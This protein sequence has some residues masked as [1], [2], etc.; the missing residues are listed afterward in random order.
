[1]IKFITNEADIARIFNNFFIDI[2][3]KLKEPTLPADFEILNNFVCD[4][5]PYD[6]D[7]K[8][9]LAL[10]RLFY[11][12]LMLTNLQD[13]IGPRT[14]K[15]SA[16]IIAPSLLFIVN[17][18]ITSGK[19]PSVWKEAKVK[20]LFKAGSKEDVNNSISILP[21]LSKL[22]E[23]SVES[24]FSQ[25]LNDFQLLHKSQSGFRSKQSTKYAL[26]LMIDSWLKAI[27]EG[28]V[29][30]CVLVDSRKAF[31]PVEHQIL[32]KKLQCYK[33]NDSRLFRFESY[34]SIRTQRFSLN[35]T[36]SDA[37]GAIYGVPQG[38]I[39]GLLLFLIFINDLTLNIQN[40][41]TSVDL[42]SDDNIFYCSNNDK[43]LLERNL[44]ACL[45]CLQRWCRENDMVLNINKIKSCL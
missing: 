13:Y 10:I 22:I 14:L 12:I 38:S 3:L 32:L 34:L 2:A 41:S 11:Q 44:Q 18:S 17:K 15:M 27:N 36:F 4:K 24:Q 1:M 42:Y 5:V 16:D 26:I 23:K 35:N 9:P 33:C 21:I 37:S 25:I 29:I 30:G 40:F 45:D 6:V 7:F 20:P 43:L 31:D 8:I 39:L 28:N 19:F